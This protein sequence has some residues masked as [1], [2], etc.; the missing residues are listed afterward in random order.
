MTQC[1]YCLLNRA[2]G[3]RLR[4]RGGAAFVRRDGRTTHRKARTYRGFVC[5]ECVQRLVMLMGEE[6]DGAL[7]AHGGVSIPR[8]DADDIVAVLT[9]LVA[10]G[11]VGLD[12]GRWRQQYVVAPT[13]PG[14]SFD[15]WFPKLL[16][17]IER[18]ANVAA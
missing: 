10:D 5:A 11:L 13:V 2:H 18:H 9:R 17:A 14:V 12:E 16:R 7:Y 1:R 8:Y 6:R 15:E 3:G 4:S